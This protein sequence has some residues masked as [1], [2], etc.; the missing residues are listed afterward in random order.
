[1]PEFPITLIKG[2]RI[3]DTP[4]TDYRDALSVNMYAVEKQI[5]GAKGYLLSWP[6]LE[7]FATVPGI[8]R[9]GSYNERFGDHYRV[10]GTSLVKISSAGTVVTLGTV[11]GSSQCRMKD[12]YSFNTQGIIA[13]G[14]FFLYSPGG[15]F[16]EVTDPDLGSPIDG[17]WID[18]YYF[19][20]DGEYLYHTDLADETAIDPLKFATAEFMPD[21]SLGLMKTTF[22]QVVVFGRYSTEYFENVATD[23]FAFQRIKS[24]AQKIGIVATHAKCESGGTFYITGGIRESDVGVHI[25]DVG[26]SVKISTREIDKIINAYS[27]PELAGMRMES[28]TDEDVS[29]IL[30]HLPNETLCFNASIGERLGKAAAWTILESDSTGANYRGING[31]VDSRISDNKQWLYGDKI[32]GRVGAINNDLFANYDALN[33]FFLYTP[34]INLE[35]LSINKVELKTIRGRNTLSDAYLYGALT[36]DGANYVAEWFQLYSNPGDLNQRFIRRVL[37]YAREW[38]GFRF[39][40]ET[41]SRMAFGLMIMDVS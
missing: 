41:R 13:D 26:K 18:G 21:P 36:Y 14:K 15:G 16:V 1:L 29:F 23:N 38:V 8:D 10:S 6:G 31:V 28:R 7:Q 19:L 35:T 24:R 20:T 17:V 30:V 3:P 11:P 2:D 27:E 32:D 39:R 33:R 25:L 37:G 9:A 5:L 12:F 40:G 4:E 34:L 22:N